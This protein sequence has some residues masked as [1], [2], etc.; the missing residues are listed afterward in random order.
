MQKFF[1]ILL[2]LLFLGCANTVY[3]TSKSTII[4]KN[5]VST[6]VIYNPQ[7]SY[8][9]FH[10]YFRQNDSQFSK[11]YPY[12]CNLPENTYCVI[13]LKPA[14]YTAAVQKFMGGYKDHF[15]LN[16]SKPDVYVLLSGFSGFEYK[17]QKPKLL[18]YEEFSFFKESMKEVV[19]IT[20]AIE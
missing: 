5:N 9:R 16:F 20:N 7:G 13:E 2:L 11:V 4:R 1:L 8:A 19:P 15:L 17:D 18:S 3:R 6:L 14:Q 10:S 12:G